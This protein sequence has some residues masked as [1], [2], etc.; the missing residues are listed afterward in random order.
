[1]NE[2][3]ITKELNG[4][5]ESKAKQI[6]EVFEP[7]VKMLEGFESAY[8]KVMQEEQS[9]EKCAKAKRLRLDIAKVRIEADKVRKS[10]KEEYLRA[11]NA[12]QGVYNVLKFAVTD[13][14]EKL[15]EVETYYDRIEAKRIAKIAEERELELE[16]YEAESTGL[17]LGNMP[18]D[19]WNNY[20]AGVKANYEAVKEAER[21]AEEERLEAE[22]K[23]KLEN[24]RRIQCSRLADFIDD[25]DDIVFSELSEGDY[26][27]IVDSAMEKRSAYEAEQEKIRKENER[28]QKE[29][30]AAEKK[31]SKERAEHE[32]AIRKER[33]ERERIEREQ[34]EKEEK[35]KREAEEKAA[36][37]A[38]EKKKAELAPDKD[39]LIDHAKTLIN[40]KDSVKSKEAKDALAR[41]AEILTTAA[42]KM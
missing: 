7:M 5:S 40:G 30:E 28:L 34:R 31:A 11:G 29:R 23:E 2:L 3:V 16:K 20:I 42:N 8:D 24:K 41:A 26:K 33:E 14:E 9:P 12:I 25:F 39:K 37:E 36:R 4:L 15:K 27:K 22:R 13:K 10:Q 18:D 35:A 1:M 17:D 21:K 38:E 32:A 19:V 6:K